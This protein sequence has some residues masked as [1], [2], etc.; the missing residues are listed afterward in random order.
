MTDTNKPPADDDA[1]RDVAARVRDYTNCTDGDID[2]LVLA[3]E[4]LRETLQAVRARAAQSVRVATPHTA[5]KPLTTKWKVAGSHVLAEPITTNE[6]EAVLTLFGKR[7]AIAFDLEYSDEGY[8]TA[9]R[10]TKFEPTDQP[11]TV[12]D[13]RSNRCHWRSHPRFLQWDVAPWSADGRP[14]LCLCAI[15]DGWGDSGTVNIFVLFADPADPSAGIEDVYVEA[16]CC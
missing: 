12:T 4:R 5:A 2:E 10:F 13:E 7:Y 1:D 11:E 3:Y 15:E 16:S 8:P 9:V 14:Y 6:S